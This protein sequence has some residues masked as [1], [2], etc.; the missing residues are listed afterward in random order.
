MMNEA[1]EDLIQIL[2]LTFME[3]DSWASL[4]VSPFARPA[5]LAVSKRLQVS[6]S[7]VIRKV[8]KHSWY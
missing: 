2:C 5:I 6:S 1:H 8:F 3:V 4:F 7:T